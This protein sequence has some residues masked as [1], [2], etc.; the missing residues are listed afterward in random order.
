[1][2]VIL[3]AIAHQ[4][5]ASDDYIESEPPINT[6]NGIHYKGAF[7]P[8]NRALINE[9]D[10]N[11]CSSGAGIYIRLFYADTLFNG[12]DL[13]ILNPKWSDINLFSFS[14]VA[15]HVVTSTITP[16]S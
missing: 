4:S 2:L 3:A 13:L 1:L 11:I 14:Y 8:L 10:A 5:C 9:K 6:G 7:Y 12:D 16:C 15:T